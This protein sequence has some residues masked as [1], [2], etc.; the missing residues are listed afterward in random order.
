MIQPLQTSFEQKS[1]ILASIPLTL[2][3]VPQLSV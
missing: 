3:Q 2:P 1:W